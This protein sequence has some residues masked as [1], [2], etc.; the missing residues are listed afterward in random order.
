MG[1]ENGFKHGSEDAKAYTGRGYAYFSYGMFRK[2]KNNPELY[3]Y[4]S[5]EYCEGYLEGYS[6]IVKNKKKSFM[7]KILNYLIKGR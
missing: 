1:Y 6:G 5:K 7:I 4:Y 2:Y 3:K